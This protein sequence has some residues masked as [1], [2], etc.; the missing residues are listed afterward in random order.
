MISA[1]CEKQTKHKCYENWCSCSC[2]SEALLELDL[3]SADARVTDPDTSKAAAEGTARKQRMLDDLLAAFWRQGNPL[4][5]EAAAEAA[6]YTPEDGAW[7]R[8]SDLKRLGLVADTGMR[9]KG[10]SGRSVAL[11]QIT[12]EGVHRV[13]R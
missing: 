11:L 3:F 2:H 7:K 6:G 5:A 1:A 9:V 12:P 4:S 13:N 10:S 8:V